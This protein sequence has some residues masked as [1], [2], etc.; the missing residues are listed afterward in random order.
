M[1]K[2]IATP[3]LFAGVVFLSV[4]ILAQAPV[5]SR[6]T[7]GRN[8]S[9]AQSGLT[10]DAAVQLFVE[11]QNLRREVTELRGMLEE[12]NYQLEQLRARQANDYA[13]LDRRILELGQGGSNQIETNS[14]AG[15]QSAALNPGVSAN[16]AQ[17]RT[18]VSQMYNQAFGS[19]R[20][21]DR[22]VAIEQ[23]NLLVQQ[24]P[25][26]DMAGDALYWLGETHWVSAAYEDARE[27]FVMLTQRFPD[28]RRYGDALYRL[29]LIYH[30]LGQNDQARQYLNQARE[31]G[32]DIGARAE[33]Y[34]NQ[35][36]TQ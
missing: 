24:H 11:L 8:S 32:G 22:A 23:F 4:S 2:N 17:S 36:L 29:G 3:A 12:S 14:P 31:L 33:E 5:E 28:N 30:Q 6:N 34:L 21:G 9:Q 27:A 1:L 18:D 20:N 19:L 10:E 35:S 16:N 25:D 13:N 7:P 15:T 26:H